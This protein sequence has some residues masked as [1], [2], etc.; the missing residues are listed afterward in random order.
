M[1]RTFDMSPYQNDG[2][3]LQGSNRSF[4]LLE[5]LQES[6]AWLGNHVCFICF[7]PP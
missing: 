2:M 5:S 7:I 4:N 3:E 1:F 6:Y